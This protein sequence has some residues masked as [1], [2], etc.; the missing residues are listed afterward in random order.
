MAGFIGMPQM[1]FYD[2][3]L[4]K[5]N[6]QYAVALESAKIVLSPEKQ[7]NLERQGVQPQAITLGVRPEHLSLTGE[8]ARM[9]H[10]T[11]DVTEMMGSAVHVHA[12]ACGHDTI[13]IVPTMDLKD[14][15]ILT[16]GS[17]VAFT[18]DGSVAHVFSRETE[19]N[20]EFGG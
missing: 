9:I 4:V 14:S 16:I 19:K 20:L 7:A 1:N 12:T 10:G 5:E 3:Q 8:G 15:S 6:G 17:P 13:M 11:V 18:F 2:A